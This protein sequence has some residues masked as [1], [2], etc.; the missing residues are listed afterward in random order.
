MDTLESGA[1]EAMEVDDTRWGYWISLAVEASLY[2]VVLGGGEGEIL[3]E[4]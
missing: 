4:G 3:A 1:V 2:L